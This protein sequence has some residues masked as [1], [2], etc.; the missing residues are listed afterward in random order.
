MLPGPTLGRHFVH[1][2]FCRELVSTALRNYFCC[3][4]LR[5]FLNRLKM[6]ACFLL[7]TKSCAGSTQCGVL[8]RAAPEN[9]HKY[10]VL[11]LVAWAARSPDPNHDSPDLPRFCCKSQIR[12][13]IPLRDVEGLEF[14][15]VAYRP[16]LDKNLFPIWDSGQVLLHIALL[17]ISFLSGILKR[18]C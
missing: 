14:H 9:E 12:S 18:Y 7:R 3:A 10:L 15:L 13:L 4:A 11:T 6:E 17:F 1:A 5:A 8:G 2:F 16:A